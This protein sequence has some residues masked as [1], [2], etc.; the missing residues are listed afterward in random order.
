MSLF[1]ISLYC[2]LKFIY[3]PNIKHAITFS[4]TSALATDVR[5]MGIMLPFLTLFIFLF[6]SL[7]E[8]NFFKKNLFSIVVFLILVPSFI[9]IFWPYLWVD[10]ITNFFV[11]FEKFSAFPWEGKNLYFGNYVNSTQVPWH[12][13]LTW[14][15][16][17]TPIFYVI[18]FIIGFHISLARVIKRLINID[19]HKELNDMWR[20]KK[21]MVDLMILFTFFLPIFLVIIL[22]ST[23]HDGWR[24][25]YFIYPSFLLLSLYGF[26]KVTKKLKRT[27]LHNYFLAFV[28]LALIVNLVNMI[29][30][31]PYQ[32]VYFNFLAGKKPEKN[33]DVDYWGLSNKQAM[34]FIFSND[35]KNIYK[36]YPA[37]N[38]DLNL[39]KL[40]FSESKKNKIKIVTEKSEADF[41]ISNGRFWDGYPNAAFAKIPDNFEIYKEIRADRTKIVSI[42][43]KISK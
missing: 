21:E 30:I 19:E 26:E 23:L 40:I 31:H 34:E 2:C 18:L 25:L 36:I 43:K 4:L 16:I 27:N 38:I 3:K 35:N 39:S 1:T 24:H 12:Y 29:R 10:P 7:R 33:F 6:L 11:A 17:T 37:S 13:T 28:I 20:G 41:M 14:I 9:I 22:N 32:N 15:A 5:L 42:Y 8:K